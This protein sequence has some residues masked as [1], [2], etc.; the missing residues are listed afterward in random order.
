M[1]D[2]TG[3]DALEKAHKVDT[4]LFDKT[5]TLTKGK[6]SVVKEKLFRPNV[7]LKDF[8]LLAASAET[9]TDHPLSGA[10]LEKACRI[11]E[12]CELNELSKE[13][14]WLLPT[15]DA[16]VRSGRGVVCWTELDSRCASFLKGSN[17]NKKTLKITIGNKPF[18][19][20][21]NIRIPKEV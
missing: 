15:K 3:G 10:I 8:Y 7:D 12:D 21:E 11:V 13:R 20:E 17:Q 6:P 18:L 16:D 1:A 19:E 2:L 5:G 4:V 14:T 9:H